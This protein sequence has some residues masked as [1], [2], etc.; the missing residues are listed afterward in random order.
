MNREFIMK[1]NHE[2]G[3]KE[4]A[5]EQTLCPCFGLERR[6]VGVAVERVLDRP[7]W[8]ALLVVV[9]TTRLDCSS[10]RVLLGAISDRS[11]SDRSI[12]DISKH[13]SSTLSS[14]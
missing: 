7:W 11:I 10:S 9:T 4:Q 6:P 2:W 1:L 5:V 12:S 14:A 8:L 13:K 3:K